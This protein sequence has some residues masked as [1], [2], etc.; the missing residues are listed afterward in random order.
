MKLQQLG[1]IFIIIVVPIAMVLSEYTANN[2][3]VLKTQAQYDTILYNSTYDAVRA[4]QMNT[5]NNG[6]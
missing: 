1:V 3:E 6:Y 5:I 2:R 4:F